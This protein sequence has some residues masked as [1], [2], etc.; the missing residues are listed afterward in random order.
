MLR[1]LELCCGKA[2]ISG[3]LKK[4]GFETM[5]LDNRKRSRVCVPDFHID[6][7][8]VKNPRSVFGQVNVVWFSPPCQCW[9]NAPGT[10]HFFE[11]TPQTES[12]KYLIKVLEK[13][14][15]IIEHLN[16]TIFFIENPRGKLR[17]YKKM[18]DFLI[19]NNGMIKQVM[20]AD[21]GFP[22]PK[23]TNIFTNFHLLELSNNARYDRGAKYTGINLN[24]M[25]VVKKQ[26]IPVLLAESIATQTAQLFNN[27][28]SCQLIP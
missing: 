20:Y 19:R 15:Q 24:D 26:T 27:S 5:T 7:L 10:Y 17:Y 21:Y 16:P 11:G 9:S 12:T 2:T 28:C 18:T 23:P 3:A 8:S 4:V 6:L 25:S 14:L 13:G 1:S 22:S